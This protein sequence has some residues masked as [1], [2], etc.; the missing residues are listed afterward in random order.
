MMTSLN[1]NPEVVSVLKFA[2]SEI[3]TWAYEGCNLKNPQ[4]RRYSLDFIAINTIYWR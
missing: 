2:R 1:M 4:L 3:R